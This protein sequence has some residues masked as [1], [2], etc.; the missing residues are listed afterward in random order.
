MFIFKRVGVG[1][2]DAS[3]IQMNALLIPVS[4]DHHKACPPNSVN[5][6]EAEPTAQAERL[7]L[8]TMGAGPCWANGQRPSLLVTSWLGP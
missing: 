2:V 8:W 1:S 3:A 6:Q 7:S 4:P 5:M